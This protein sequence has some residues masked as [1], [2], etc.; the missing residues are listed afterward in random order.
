MGMPNLLD[1]QSAT[2]HDD[3]LS[4]AADAPLLNSDSKIL[5]EEPALLM[6]YYR[7]ALPIR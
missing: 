1:T 7:A 2:L 3:A 5:P 6:D 4:I